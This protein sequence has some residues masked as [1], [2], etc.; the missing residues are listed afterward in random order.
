MTT[1]IP[2]EEWRKFFDNLS[3]DLEGWETHIEVLGDEVGAQVLSQGL[4]FHGLT[5]EAKA[6]QST[7]DLIVGHGADRHQSHTVA[8]PVKV[9]FE[10][11]GL[12]PAG[13]LSI[14][15]AAGTRTLIEF[16]QPCPILLEYV[17]TELVRVTPGHKY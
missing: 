5:C 4:P 11:S 7:I 10:G 13:V 1:E 3:R 14:E 2:K 17:N 16:V 9:S 12:G 6:G 15:D 8:T